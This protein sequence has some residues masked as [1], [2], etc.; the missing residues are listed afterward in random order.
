MT[1]ELAPGVRSVRTQKR[2]GVESSLVGDGRP[3][4][5]AEYSLFASALSDH[6]T[7][8]GNLFIHTHALPERLPI[9]QQDF[10]WLSHGDPA[11]EHNALPRKRQQYRQEGIDA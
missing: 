4:K 5:P 3:R 9:I 10:G 11:R 2:T 1:I 7:G 6:E 8:F